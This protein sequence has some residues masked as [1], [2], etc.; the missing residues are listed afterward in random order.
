MQDQENAGVQPAETTDN[1]SQIRVTALSSN[2]TLFWRIFI[3]VFGTVLLSGLFLG[4]FLSEEGADR[5][6]LVP[7]WVVRIVMV[8]VMALWFWSVKR[9]FLSLKRIDADDQYLFVTNYWTTVRYPWFDVE[10][11]DMTKQL[12]SPLS[13]LMLKAPGRFGQA[14]PF[15]PASHFQSWMEEQGKA[16]LIVQPAQEP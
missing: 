5:H 7:L 2:S 3:P 6:P 12:G 14:I 1:P 10:R 15:K 8:L 11:I 9:Y 4:I 13:L 16:A